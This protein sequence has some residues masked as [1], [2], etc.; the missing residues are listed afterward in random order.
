VASSPAVA[1]GVVYVGS[2]DGK[3][4]ALDATSGL[5]IWD[6]QTDEKV[7]SSPAVAD[8]EVYVGSYDHFVYAV[9]SSAKAI[10]LL[11][12]T[13]S[14]LPTGLNWSLKLGDV[15][16]T[17]DS[18][19]I[20]FTVPI[21]THAFEVTAPKGYTASPNMGTVTVESDLNIEVR[22]GAEASWTGILTVVASLLLVGALLVFLTYRRK[23]FAANCLTRG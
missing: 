17:S 6:Y 12:F 9:G 11:S 21:G 14:G 10:Y 19:V 2:Y 3:I 1:G 20:A 22:L 18:N 5:L 13:A 4:Y 8:G 16:E 7:V 23:K 15:T